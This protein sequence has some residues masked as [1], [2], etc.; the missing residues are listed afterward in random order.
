LGGESTCVKRVV[1]GE[2]L[3]LSMSGQLA[4]HVGVGDV[5]AETKD[6]AM[7]ASNAKRNCMCIGQ[8]LEKNENV[9]E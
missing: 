6:M 3:P 7:R 2:L 4:L 8:A 5:S 9:V 1:G